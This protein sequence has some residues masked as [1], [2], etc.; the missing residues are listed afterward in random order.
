M[1]AEEQKQEGEDPKPVDKTRKSSN[2]FVPMHILYELVKRG[3]STYQIEI[4]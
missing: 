3:T 1:L 4:V 2:S